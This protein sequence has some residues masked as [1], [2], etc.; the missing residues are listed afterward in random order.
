MILENVDRS[1]EQFKQEIKKNYLRFNIYVLLNLTLMVLGAIMFFY[2]EEC[3]FFVP[4]GS[5]E[6]NKQCLEICEDLIMFNKTY[7]EN[8]DHN[9]TSK[10]LKNITDT[11]IKKCTPEI[12]PAEKRCTLDTIGI[13]RWV[14][15]TQSIQ[16]TIGTLHNS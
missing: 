15:Y 8:I 16:F 5:P 7:S 9:Q 3:Y 11:C 4:E 1:K 10:A 2:V 12:L 14:E 6:S 13:L